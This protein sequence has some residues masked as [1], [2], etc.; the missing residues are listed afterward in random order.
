MQMERLAFIL[1]LVVTKLTLAS[2]GKGVLDSNEVCRP[3]QIAI[4]EC[5]AEE[6]E[7]NPSRLMIEIQ[8]QNCERRYPINMCYYR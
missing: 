3:Q 1:I 7:K 4:A 2:C 5:I 6:Y 8:R